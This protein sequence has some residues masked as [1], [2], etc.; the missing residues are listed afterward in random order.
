MSYARPKI[1]GDKDI[2]EW[3]K[4]KQ[5]GGK[6]DPNTVRHI[7]RQLEKGNV[8]S[9][10]AA[11]KYGAG[12]Y[13][14][15]RQRFMR[16]A[17]AYGGTGGFAEAVGKDA[18]ANVA[19]L[20]G[21]KVGKGNVY[22]GSTE[23]E[24]ADR[25]FAN[26][27]GWHSRPGGKS[28]VPTVLPRGVYSQARGSRAAAADDAGSS[29]NPA[30]TGPSPDLLAAREA[31]DRANAYSGQNG[32]DA[33]SFAALPDLSK[34]GGDLFNEI[35][36]AGQRQ[37]DNYQNRFLP[38]LFATANLTAQEIG[39]S[40][41]DAIASLPDDLSLPEYTSMFGDKNERKIEK[42]GLYDFLSRGIA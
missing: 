9:S 22:A 13:D 29:A 42:R 12:K 10:Q 19:G 2:Q 37:L 21:I 38:K 11:N 35:Q 5:A 18:P 26:R 40:T 17:G 39:A 23:V 32:A 15:D 41:Q 27:D 7:A 3:I 14:T 31:Y 25:S 36:A 16:S 20:D 28:F 34:T 6:D 4:R 30:N 8:L 33:G 24:T 1:I